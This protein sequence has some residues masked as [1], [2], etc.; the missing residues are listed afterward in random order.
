MK[1]KCNE[2]VT[3][4]FKLHYLTFPGL[5]SVVKPWWHKMAY[6]VQKATCVLWYQESKFVVS[7]QSNNV[8]YMVRNHHKNVHL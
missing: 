3:N 5:L 2:V 6:H 1:T 4:I 8:L 7:M